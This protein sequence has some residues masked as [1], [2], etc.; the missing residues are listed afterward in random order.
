MVCSQSQLT[1]FFRNS[2]KKKHVLKLLLIRMRTKTMHANRTHA[3]T[4]PDV[5]A[6]LA[7]M[8]FTA[9]AQEPLWA[10]HAIRVWN[11]SKNGTLVQ[12]TNID[13]ASRRIR[14]QR[15]F[16]WLHDGCVRQRFRR[17]RGRTECLS[18]R[19][20]GYSNDSQHGSCIPNPVGQLDRR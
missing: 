17:E 5:R 4:A 16:E 18:T 6:Y 12:F 10:K 14:Q 3:K 19:S 15:L 20:R 2:L 7:D 9:I 8:I 1:S 11:L 13:F